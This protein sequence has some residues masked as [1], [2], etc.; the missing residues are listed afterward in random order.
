[1]AAGRHDRPAKKDDQ[2]TPSWQGFQYA[3]VCKMELSGIV[4]FCMAMQ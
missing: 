2:H 3:G 4:V 1:M